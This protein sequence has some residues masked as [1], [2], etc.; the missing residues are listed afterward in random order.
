M[1]FTNRYNLPETLLRAAVAQNAKYNKGKVERSVTQLLQPPRI[2]ILRRKHFP[3][4]EKDLSEEFW[5]LFGSAVHYILELG[6]TPNMICE[7]RF[8]LT[9]AGWDVSGAVDCQEFHDKGTSV[10]LVDYKVTTA[11]V[12]MK[13]EDGQK[14]EWE[15]QLNMLAYMVAMTKGIRIRDIAIV[16]I[17]RDWQR[18][19]GQSDPLYPI[20]PVVRINLPLWTPQRQA[21]FMAERVR[22]HR[23][24]EMLSDLDQPMPDCTDEERWSR[25]HSWAVLREGAKRASKVHYDEASAIA[26]VM[27]RNDHNKGKPFR[28]DFRPG[29]SVRCEGN[30]CQVAPWC[31]QYSRIKE[32]EHEIS[33]VDDTESAGV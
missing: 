30:Y 20:A 25:Q 24:A 23:E 15:Q 5:A 19:Q 9:V 26:D 12:V 8:F 4:I 6:K 13:D 22:L 28:F 1:K 11:F 18:S 14:P 33:R 29:K 7:E 3:E 2:D 10:S 21:E 31:E 17:I 32:E 16:A 27:E